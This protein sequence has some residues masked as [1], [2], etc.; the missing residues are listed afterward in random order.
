M[1]NEVAEVF[2]SNAL[3]KALE[4]W[5]AKGLKRITVV[6]DGSGDEGCLESLTCTPADVTLDDYVS[7]LLDDAATDFMLGSFDEEGGGI[8]M[9]IDLETMMINCHEYCYQTIVE[10]VQERT[11]RL[12]CCEREEG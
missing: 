3:F 4:V 1:C 7:D 8:K 2:A 11:L 6:C 5:K 9:E 12:T 10:D